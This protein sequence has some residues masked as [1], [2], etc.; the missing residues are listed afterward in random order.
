MA[1]IRQDLPLTAGTTPN[2]AVGGTVYSDPSLVGWSFSVERRSLGTLTLGVDYTLLPDGTGFT[3]IGSTFGNPIT[4]GDGEVYTLHFY[5]QE[6][7]V[8]P[9]QTTGVTNG[10]NLARVY[11]A[12]QGRLGWEQPDSSLCPFTLSDSNLAATSGRY[13]GEEFH[14]A[15]TLINIINAQ[16]QANPTTDDFNALLQRMDRGLIM[17]SLNAIF[18]RNMLIEHCLNYTRSSNVR[19]VVIPNQAN[20][21]GYRINIAQ[22]DWSLKLDSVSMFFDGV[23][24]F[25]LYLFNDLQKLPV[26]TKSITTQANT[27][28][29]VQLDWI[30]NYVNETGNGGIYYLGYF[31]NDLPT[32]VHAIDEQ[33][34]L[35]ANTKIFG[36]Y[37]FQSQ[38]QNGLDFNRIN[39][40]VVYRSYGINIEFSAYY[41]YTEKIIQNANLFD[42]ARGLLMAIR[43]I[44]MIQYSGN[45]NGKNRS[46]D[47]KTAGLMVQ[48]ANQAMPTEQMPYVAGIKSQVM[49]EFKRMN[50]NFFSKPQAGSFTLDND[51]YKGI[52]AYDSFDLAT[53]PPRENMM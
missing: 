24:T 49:R 50:D 31:Q 25:N 5:P 30:I 7:T 14:E 37:P 11:A 42:E 35:W 3:I 2:M 18:N 48:S 15:C 39:P 32:D 34:N 22:G 19:N 33:L 40:S 13:Y 6:L 23:A 51:Q 27:Q 21:C 8:T 9:P 43:V 52:F 29:K 12:F 1:T 53:L 45:N 4:F 46:M 16:P 41:D 10:Y 26:L 44:E 47:E 17:R 36:S 28:T 38:Q 20:F